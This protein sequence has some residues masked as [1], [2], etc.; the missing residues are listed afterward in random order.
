MIQ[1][2]DCRNLRPSFCLISILIL[3]SARI[4]QLHSSVKSRGTH[5]YKW[6]FH[7]IFW[8]QNKCF[9]SIVSKAFCFRLVGFNR[10]STVAT[11]ITALGNKY[12]QSLSKDINTMKH[13]YPSAIALKSYFAKDPFEQIHSKSSILRKG[14]EDLDAP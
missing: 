14:H 6:G 12:Y 2:S 5:R 1:I 10:I 13:W 3:L 7:Q 11:K 8:E 4:A 9:S